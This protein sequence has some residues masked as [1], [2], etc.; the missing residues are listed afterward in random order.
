MRRCSLL[1]ILFFTACSSVQNQ[2]QDRLSELN[3]YW[4]E[5]SRCVG[6]GDFAGYKAT[7]HEKG[8]LVY[9]PGEKAYPLAQALAKWKQEFDDTKSGKIQAG[10]SFRFSKRIGDESTAF[11]TGMFLYYQIKADGSKKQ[12]YIHLEALLVKENGAWK[13]LM[14]N[15]KAKGTKSEWDKLG[16]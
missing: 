11:E 6:E 15:Q 4:A 3:Q 5:V 16:K 12:E 13:I 8:V 14:E 2:S 9:E 10:V 7:C 1:A